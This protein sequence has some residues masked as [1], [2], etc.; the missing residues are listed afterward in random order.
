MREIL[1]RGVM[2]GLN[3]AGRAEGIIGCLRARLFD[4]DAKRPRVTSKG[5]VSRG[6]NFGRG[7]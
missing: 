2:A 1:I 7:G 5:L 6:A 4:V 3:T